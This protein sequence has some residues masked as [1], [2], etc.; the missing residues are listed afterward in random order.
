MNITEKSAKKYLM[1][2]AMIF[3]LL[4]SMVGNGALTVHAKEKVKEK[5]PFQIIPIFPKNQDKNIKQYMSL[6]SS[7]GV[8]QTVYFKLINNTKAKKD[9]KLKVLN[10]YTSPN[11]VIQYE[12]KKTKE[13][14][15]IDEKYEM[16]KYATI[17]KSISVNPNES[18]VVPVELNM[19]K[20]TGTVLGGIAFQMNVDN[21]KPQT[22]KKTNFTIK[23]EV[24]LIYGLA[25]N[26]SKNHPVKFSFGDV[27]VDPMA[28]YYAVRLPIT[29]H[30]PKIL[31]NAHVEYEVWYKG[32]KLFFDK[33]EMKFAPKTKTNFAIPFNYKKIKQGKYE[34][35]GKIKYVEEDGTKHEE[36]FDKKFDYDKNDKTGIVNKIKQPIE[37]SS[38]WMKILILIGLLLLIALPFLFFFLKKKKEKDAEKAVEKAE[39]TLLASDFNVAQKLVLKLSKR[40][41]KRKLLQM[42]LD[43]VKEKIQNLKS[44]SKTNEE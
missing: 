32:K 20:V 14:K 9:L 24:N 17:Q 34:L 1:F 19:P 28:T 16:K 25:V 5:P 23:N 27:Y 36:K 21:Q 39:E 31:Q 10:A 15:I 8:N 29:M 30:S 44:E 6:T 40:S 4:I 13:S 2:I 33:K 18:K 12:T 42:R 37:D 22:N 26:S 35:K 7:N 38:N 41:D 3:T 43:V 11:A